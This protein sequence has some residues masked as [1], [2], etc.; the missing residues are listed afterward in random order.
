[1]DPPQ[2]YRIA[3]SFRRRNF[4]FAAGRPDFAVNDVA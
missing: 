3:R 1:M 2:E 4:S